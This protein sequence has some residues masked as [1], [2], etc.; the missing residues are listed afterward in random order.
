MS[1][2]NI[3]AGVIPS[4][5]KIVVYGPEGIGKST[6]ASSFPNALF[7]DTEGSTKYLPVRRLDTPTS[8]QMLKDEIEYVRQNPTVCDT[9]VIDT[10]DWAESH[11][12]KAICDKSNKTGIEDF[13]YGKGYIYEKE[14]IARFLHSLDDVV[15]QGIHVVLTAHAQL[16]KVE[17]PENTGTYDHWEMKLGQ[18]TGSLISPMVKE[19]ADMVLFANYK[20]IVVAQNNKG[21]KH[22]ATG[23]RRV[24]YTNHTPWWDAKNRFGLPE[25]MDFLFGNIAGVLIPR[26]QLGTD[27]AMETVYQQKAET[28]AAAAREQQSR[29]ETFVEE[30]PAAAAIPKPAPPA[31][32]KPTFTPAPPGLPKALT[33]LMTADGITEADIR[34]AVARQGIY[35]EDTPVTD[36]DDRTL[37]GLIIGQWDGLKS[38]I[39]QLKGE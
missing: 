12:I 35:P 23:G 4:A 38:F 19:W 36:Y 24:M 22:K 13:G 25:E 1:N 34:M 21:T 11:C 32:E 6:F 37:N 8:W 39:K 31:R 26:E 27:R 14:E 3:T 9:L 15:A 29:V 20:T 2:F 7:I 28:M 10:F 17:Q 5:L 16:R 30:P 33:D 18:K